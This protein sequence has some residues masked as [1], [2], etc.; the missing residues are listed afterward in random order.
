MHFPAGPLPSSSPFYDARRSPFVAF[1]CRFTDPSPFVSGRGYCVGQGV[2][3]VSTEVVGFLRCGLGFVRKLYSFHGVCV[4][5][6]FKDDV[7]FNSF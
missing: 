5:S 2:L 1:P 3:V 4:M 7:Y 6:L